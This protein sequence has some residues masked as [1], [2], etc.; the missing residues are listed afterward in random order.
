MKRLLLGQWSM[1]IFLEIYKYVSLIKTIKNSR[2]VEFGDNRWLEYAMDKLDDT[3]LDGRR[4]KL[5]EEKPRGDV[6]RS[7][8]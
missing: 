6:S 4:I 2:I 5:I 1:K 8:I 3:E 7:K